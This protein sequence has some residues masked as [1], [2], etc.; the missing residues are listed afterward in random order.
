MV[1]VNI[2]LVAETPSIKRAAVYHNS[3]DLM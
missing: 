2:C 3:F 1:L